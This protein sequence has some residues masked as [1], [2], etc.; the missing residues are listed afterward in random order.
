M[1]LTE[2]VTGSMATNLDLQRELVD[3]LNRFIAIAVDELFYVYEIGH[4]AFRPRKRQCCFEL[5]VLDL[6][7]TFLLM[8]KWNCL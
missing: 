8:T 6:T 5:G 4:K 3:I 2:R 7:I 1:G